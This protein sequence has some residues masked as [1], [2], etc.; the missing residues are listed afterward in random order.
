MEPILVDSSVWIDFFNKN[1][2]PQVRQLDDLLL[3]D[4][5]VCICPPVLQEV[6]QGL[7]PGN[8]YDR[9]FQNLM[10]QE[11]L[12]CE[13]VMAAVNAADI[14]NRL[15]KNGITIRKSNDCLIAYHAIHFDASV[16]HKDRDF[17]LLSKFTTMKLF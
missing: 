5:R 8:Y 7:A 6:L 11:I 1:A 16:L 15:R 9:V 2:T 14:Y 10:M 13:P 4:K 3:K 17:S 12:I